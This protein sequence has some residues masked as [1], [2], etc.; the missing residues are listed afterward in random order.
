MKIKYLIYYVIFEI[1][2]YKLFKIIFSEI[3]SKYDY[4]EWVEY[5]Y[6]PSKNIYFYFYFYFILTTSVFFVLSLFYKN[7]KKVEDNVK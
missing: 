1:V 4:L 2:S 7:Y 5:F 6:Y 3:N